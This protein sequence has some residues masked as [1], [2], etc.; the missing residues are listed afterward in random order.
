M[1]VTQTNNRAR[2]D[3]EI[4]AIPHLTY[5]YENQ[6]VNSGNGMNYV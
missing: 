6:E 4:H 2:I 5:E 3:K 1:S